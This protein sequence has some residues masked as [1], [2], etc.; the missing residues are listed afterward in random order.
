MYYDSDTEKRMLTILKAREERSSFQKELINRYHQSLISY[1]LNI[2]GKIKR[3]TEIDMFFYVGWEKILSLLTTENILHLSVKDKPT[4]LEGFVVSSENA[5]QLK[6]RM[7]QLEESIPPF[8][9]LDI[10]VFDKDFTQISRRE[11]KLPPRRCLLC[12][13]EAALCCK[14]QTHNSFELSAY[15]QK[16]IHEFLSERRAQS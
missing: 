16:L 2:P 8:R 11:C 4:G 14:M 13:Q 6:R 15:C 9:L 3:S 1:T 5:E 10:D 7:I 12:S